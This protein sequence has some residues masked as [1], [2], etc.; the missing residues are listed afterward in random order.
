MA[1]DI[2][3]PRRIKFEVN[4][5]NHVNYRFKRL[6]IAGVCRLDSKTNDLLQLT[7]LLIGAINYELLIKE[8]II[9]K[10]SRFKGQFVER[11]RDNLGVKTLT[12]NFRN[13]TFNIHYHADDKIG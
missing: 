13:Y 8:K 3:T 7:D 6:A 11:F 4:I 9:D 2:T 12:E 5:K 10:M 1:D